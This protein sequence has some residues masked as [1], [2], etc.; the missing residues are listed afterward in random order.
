MSEKNNKTIGFI[1]LGTMGFP[2]ASKILESGHRIC[3]YDID[4]SRVKKML[5]KG[6]STAGN[7]KEVASKSD[8]IMNI[9]PD[10]RNVEEVMFGKDGVIEGTHQGQAIVEMSTVPPD[11]IKKIWR[12][13]RKRGV[14]VIDAAV[15]RTPVHAER[16]ELMILV[17]GKERVIQEHKQV[18]DCIA[19]EIVHCGDI[20]SGVTMKLI[21]NMCVQNICMAVNESLT[22]GVKSKLDLK[23]MISVLSS[24]AASNKVVEEVYPNSLFINNFSLGFSLN[25]AHKDVGHAL[26]L[27][28]DNSVPCPVAAITHQW[29]S[30]ARSKGMGNKDHSSLATIIENMVDVRLRI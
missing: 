1:G 24:T 20:G 13:A 15:C 10:V 30:I 23:Q 29:Q 21:N 14:D 5:E 22:L 26:K 28:A 17:G 4:K 2:I 25:L 7:C 3:V 6:A 27:A 19:N 12:T 16:G 18:F 8:L 9:V 11:T